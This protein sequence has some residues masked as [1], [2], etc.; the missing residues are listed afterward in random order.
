MKNNIKYFLVLLT[1]M[2]VVAG[3]SA[4]ESNQKKVAVHNFTI[5]SD[6]TKE[7][8]N[9]W[10][11][12]GKLESD[13]VQN[14][15]YRVFTRAHISKVLKE[16]NILQD[17]S[18][19]PNKL[20][21]ILGADFI[22]TG[23]IDRAGQCVTVVCE[24][25][26]VRKDAGEVKQSFKS[27]YFIPVGADSLYQL[28]F[29]FAELAEKLS[30]SPGS[31]LEK[32][33]ALLEAKDYNDALKLFRQLKK[34]SAFS[35]LIE[36]AGKLDDK[37]IELPDK[38]K[39]EK[40]TIGQLFDYAASLQEKDPKQAA[41]IICWLEKNKI[42]KKLASLEDTADAESKK[43]RD[44]IKQKLADAKKNFKKVMGVK[45]EKTHE[46]C[47][48]LVSELRN[49]QMDPY[50]NATQEEKFEIDQALYKIESYRM[51]LSGGPVVASAW[52]LPETDISLV[53]LKAGSFMMGAKPEEQ[54]ES[55]IFD[56]LQHKVII[57]RPFWISKMEITIADYVYYLQQA[58]LVDKAGKD[59]RDKEVHFENKN[60]PIVQ[61]GYKMKRGRGPY[62]GDKKQ[63]MNFVTW[64]GARRFCEWLTM[65]ERRAR[66]LPAGYVYRLPTEAEWEYAIRAGTSTVFSF[67]DEVKLLPEYAWF[68]TNSKKETHPA[69]KKKANLWGLYDMN[70]NVWEWC[71]D[72]YDG[73][74]NTEVIKDPRGAKSSMENLKV[75]RGG[76]FSSGESV[77][78][79]ATRDSFPYKYAKK[80]IGFRIVLAPE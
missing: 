42:K 65:R 53:P 73:P 78:P 45:G 29:V 55:Q 79:T 16:R 32:G 68:K 3:L 64:K 74:Y 33:L 80:S 22:V 19:T 58:M 35:K 62:W 57:T 6:L 10:F 30:M 13:L 1:F 50:L 60:C 51:G 36:W 67:G 76:G 24:L 39:L 18:I 47:E 26:D 2:F 41:Q 77:M 31:Y 20:G 40:K 63:P 43:Q 44:E 5:S 37:T 14:G 12:A 71:D 4:A 49:M 9:G 15:Y 17:A 66:R 8:L 38:D 70:G 46:T 72:W 11:C 34:N 48:E 25:I 28:D 23:Q 59:D 54:K 7:G 75:I 69:G 61:D 27:S 52:G 56:N 21:E